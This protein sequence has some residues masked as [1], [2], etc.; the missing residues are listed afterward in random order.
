MRLSFNPFFVI[1][2]R[3]TAELAV[4]YRTSNQE[5]GDPIIQVDSRLMQMTFLAEH[6]FL[7]ELFAVQET[8]E[9][10]GGQNDH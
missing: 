1:I 7:A 3:I 10:N 2:H 4:Y 6:K 9:G 5:K 8:S